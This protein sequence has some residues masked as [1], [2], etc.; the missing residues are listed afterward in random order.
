MKFSDGVEFALASL[1][2][3]RLRTFLTASGVMIGIGAL[4]SMISFGKGM[5]K[6]VTEAFKA[7][8]LFNAVMVMPG[9]GEVPFGDPDQRPR[10]GEKA[11]RADAVLDD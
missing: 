7:S 1:R 5:Q 4:V 6:N 2:K 8:D 3:R 10:P 11:G 9:G